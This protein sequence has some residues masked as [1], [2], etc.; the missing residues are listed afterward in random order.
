ML[1]LMNPEGVPEE[2]HE[3]FNIDT[4]LEKIEDTTFDS[5]LFYQTLGGNSFQVLMYYFFRENSLSETFDLDL[6]LLLQAS[7]AIQQGYFDDNP[8]HNPTHIIDTL[9]GM[10]YLFISSAQRKPLKR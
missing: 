4:H 6:R 3:Y 10:H 2:A 9:Q 5:F 7:F 8:Y 1:E